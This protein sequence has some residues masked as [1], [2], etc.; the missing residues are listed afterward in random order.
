MLPEEVSLGQVP[1]RHTMPDGRLVSIDVRAIRHDGEVDR[2]LVALIDITDLDAAERQAEHASVLVDLIRRRSAFRLMLKDAFGSL[3]NLN[4]PGEIEKRRTIHTIKGN[5]GIFGLREIAEL[6]HDLEEAPS[7]PSDAP[8]R[9][10]KAMCDYIDSI[11][12]VLGFDASRLDEMTLDISH[13]DLDHLSK[14]VRTK[15]DSKM[16]KK[17]VQTR[18]QKRISALLGPLDMQAQRIASRLGK[19][20]SLRIIGGDNRV[21]PVAIQSILRAIPHLVRNAIDHGLEPLIER[22]DK[23]AEGRIEGSF[24]ERGAALIVKVADD[25]RGIDLERIRARLIERG[26]LTEAEIADMNENELLNGIFFDGFSLKDEV[27]DVSGRGVGAPA[28]K[29]AVEA[30]GGVVRVKSVV[31]EGTTVTLRIPRSATTEAPVSGFFAQT[32]PEQVDART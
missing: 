18:K 24:E 8:E 11:A 31:G 19:Q 3:S 7:I 4:N 17:W 25:G 6:A 28:V 15:T 5:A 2:L 1:K 14:S 30:V 13:T 26:F 9:L 22:G 21:D 16:V 10:A 27:T 23:P 12:D 32:V 20:A 29:A